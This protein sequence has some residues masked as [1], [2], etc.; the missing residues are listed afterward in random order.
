[1]QPRE[2]YAVESNSRHIRILYMYEKVVYD[3][4]YGKKWRSA[5]LESFTGKYTDLG[6]WELVRDLPPGRKA[7]KGKWVFSVKLKPDKLIE[8]F[9]ALRRLWLQP[10]RRHRL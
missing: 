6:L 9:K 3:P 8:K 10:D 4:V 2:V 5:C 7:I 1:M